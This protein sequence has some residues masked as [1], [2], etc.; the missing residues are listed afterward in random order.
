MLG[1]VIDTVMSSLSFASQH[2]TWQQRLKHE[3][4][5]AEK[6][7]IA[8]TRCRVA[9]ASNPNC[10]RDIPFHHTLPLY[11]AVQ[12]HPANPRTLSR[13][14]MTL[15]TALEE[16]KPAEVRGKYTGQKFARAA[17]VCDQTKKT[18]ESTQTTIPTGPK[19]RKVRP[20][21]A[22]AM[23][24]YAGLL[25]RMLTREQKVRAMHRSGKRLR[26]C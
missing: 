26:Q 1:V 17:S 25:Q 5:S 8:V 21:S 23:T 9:G 16:Q 2:R 22:L 19:R 14:S 15:N 6:S 10:I 13:L 4:M 18:E 20:V 12:L 24:V 3:A 11:T 7:Q